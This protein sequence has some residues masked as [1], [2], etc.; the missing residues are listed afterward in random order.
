MVRVSFWLNPKPYIISCRPHLGNVVTDVI[1][2]VHLQIIWAAPAPKTSTRK[3][4][5]F[6][7]QA[8]YLAF[9]YTIMGALGEGTLAHSAFM[10]A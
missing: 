3:L 8:Y 5:S 2:Q 10:A 7:F 4:T 1:H 6:M 9:A